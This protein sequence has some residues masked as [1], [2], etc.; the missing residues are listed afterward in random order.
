MRII[1]SIFTKARKHTVVCQGDSLT[2]F[3]GNGSPEWVRWT[4]SLRLKLEAAGARVDV[5]NIGQSGAKTDDLGKGMLLRFTPFLRGVPD[6]GILWG[7]TNDNRGISSLT[8]SGTTATA[9]ST[10]HGFYE[11]ALVS[12]TGAAPSG[13]NVANAPIH[14]VDANTF[15]FA[16]PTGLSSPASGTIYAWPIPRSA[17]GP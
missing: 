8:V 13:F 7:G 11:T 15:T 2:D 3:D 9:V 4:E 5:C 17:C 16:V 6:I 14:V 1:Q 12:I 10:S